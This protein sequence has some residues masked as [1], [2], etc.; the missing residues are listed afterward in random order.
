MLQPRVPST[1]FSCLC[2]HLAFA[3]FVAPFQIPTSLTSEVLASW[4]WAYVM[5]LSR[6]PMIPCPMLG[7]LCLGHGRGGGGGAVVD[8][9]GGGPAQTPPSPPLVTKK[10]TIFGHKKVN[11]KQVILGSPQPVHVHGTGWEGDVTRHMTALWMQHCQCHS[12]SFNVITQSDTIVLHGAAT[13]T[14]LVIITATIAAV[15]TE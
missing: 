5:R 14:W 8:I 11:L 6:G 4:S 2:V 1:A 9:I 10:V 13:T 12:M 3:Q 7:F 15:A